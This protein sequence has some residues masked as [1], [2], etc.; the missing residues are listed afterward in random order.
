MFNNMRKFTI[1]FLFLL[2]CTAFGQHI[3]KS[4]KIISISC[5]QSLGHCNYKVIK[6]FEDTV[7][8]DNCFNQTSNNFTVDR[9]ELVIAN[10]MYSQI[11]K[12][13]DEQWLQIENNLNNIKNCDYA[14]PFTIQIIENNK[15]VSFSLKRFT[16]CY[17]N[18]VKQIMDGLDTYFNR[19]Q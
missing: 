18:S 4:S 7:Q 16:N 9:T 8:I 11:I 5:L 12:E 2:T 1:I 10:P 15:T 13:T 19:L 6:I 3:I 14:D 17:P